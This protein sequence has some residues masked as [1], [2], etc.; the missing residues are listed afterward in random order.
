MRGFFVSVDA[1]ID[2]VFRTMTLA[3]PVQRVLKIGILL[4]AGFALHRFRAGRHQVLNALDGVLA[5]LFRQGFA[6][7]SH[8]LGH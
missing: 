8:A 3:Q 1:G 4:F 6:E 7:R 5:H 2:H